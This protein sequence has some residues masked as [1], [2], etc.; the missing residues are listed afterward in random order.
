ML[1]CYTE[2]QSLKS[3]FF[4][5]QY[6][7]DYQKP[8]IVT[9]FPGPKHLQA[10]ET[11]DAT[12]SSDLASD[13]LRFIDLKASK[14]N[15][16]KDVDGNVVLD[17]NCGQALGYNHDVLVNAR[18]S[19]VYDRFLGGKIDVGTVPPSDY[20]DILRTDVM[21]VAPSGMTQV[22]LS[23]GSATS[24][25]DV[26]IATA[27][28]H[29]AMKNGSETLANYSVMGFEGASHGQS[30]STLSVSDAA[31]NVQGLPT[32]DW[33]TAPLPKLKYPLAMN[34]AENTAEEDRCIAATKDLI[35]SQK[36]AGR[37]VA[38]MIIEPISSFENRQATPAYYKKLRAVAAESGIPFIVD[39]T[40]TGCGQTG[41]MWA[42]EHWW[43]SDRDGGCPDFV[44]F[45]GKAGISGFYSTYENRMHPSCPSGEQFVDMTQVITYGLTWKEVHRKELLELVQDTSS[46]L[47]IELGNIERETGLIENV[48]GNGTFIGF[49]VVSEDTDS[50]MRWL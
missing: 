6:P 9:G 35:A 29:Y 46:F 16:F 12:Q 50:V 1:C 45:G 40:K 44:T 5:F 37:D 38:A 33:P 39:E 49:D 7:N 30:V 18:D 22:H 34:E 2:M 23:D 3:K 27:T 28:F 8:K 10:L 48:R 41:K 20:A 24:A 25:N 47:K 32:F 14:G 17:L 26:A 15:F 4:R 21:P 43:L 31:V 11:A 42:H 19:A 13:G 36:T